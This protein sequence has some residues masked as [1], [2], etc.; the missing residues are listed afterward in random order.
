M[1]DA[2]AKPARRSGEDRELLLRYAAYVL[3]TIR[4]DK[5]TGAPLVPAGVLAQIAGRRYTGRTPGIQTLERLR[6]LLP[7]TE[8]TDSSFTENQVRSLTCDGL[9]ARVHE[10]WSEY[11]EQ[12]SAWPGARVDLA[13]GARLDT[14]RA[15]R[16]RNEE[17]AEFQRDMAEQAHHPAARRVL[18]YFAELPP[19]VY[20]AIMRDG[21]ESARD[22]ALGIGD[23]VKRR[24]NLNLLEMAR[25]NPRPVMGPSSKG[26]TVRVFAQGASMLG[27]SRPVR[28]ALTRPNCVWLDLASSQLAIVAQQW[29][30]PEAD[31]FLRS[32][33]GQKGKTSV[34]PSLIAS[35]GPEGERLCREQSS[36]PGDFDDAKGV[37]KRFLYA[38]IFGA[39]REALSTLRFKEEGGGETLDLAGV[40]SDA[41]MVSR[42]TAPAW[43]KRLLAHPLSTALMR[44]RSAR[45]K[46]VLQQREAVDCF[47]ERIRVLNRSDAVSA[48]AQLAQAQEMQLMLPAL[49][50]ARRRPK[51]CCVAL[52]L[53]DGIALHVKDK[54]RQESVIRAICGAVDDEAKVRG[55]QTFLER[56]CEVDQKQRG[57][58]END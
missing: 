41:L 1:S 56:Q 6:E 9:P 11:L 26:N 4:R 46:Q 53:H 40:L 5:V 7:E 51:K 39:G 45:I 27:I 30:V 48:L 33:P 16:R 22:V 34:W 10:I 20:S 28:S 3:T 42:E 57:K 31:P 24:C 29:N 35:L 17:A 38:L 37:T 25:D 14:P 58:L 50:E 52:W 19:H 54:S 36:R 21:L 47:G 15:I 44:A 43:G 49:D 8:W 32:C 18:N 55:I 13:T 23:P 12:P 2:L